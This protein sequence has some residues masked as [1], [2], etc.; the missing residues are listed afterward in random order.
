MYIYMY[1]YYWTCYIHSF[2]TLYFLHSILHCKYFVHPLGYLVEPCVYRDGDEILTSYSKLR[3][4]ICIIA[5]SLTWFDQ[6]MITSYDYW[7]S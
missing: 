5:H 1:I 2:Y 7:V 4:S 3:L 6:I